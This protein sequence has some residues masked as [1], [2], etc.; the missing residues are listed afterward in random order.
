MNKKSKKEDLLAYAGSYRPLSVFGC[1]LAGI[2]AVL[3]VIPFICIWFA[4]REVF[5]NISDLSKIE[6]GKWGWLAVAFAA[7]SMA[8][9]FAGLMCTHIAAFRT[10][11]NLRS[12]ALHHLM[13][14]PLG[15]F[16]SHNS[17]RIRREIDDCASQTESYLAH[18]LPDLTAAKVTPA[19]AAILLFV[20]DWR[21][22]LISL[23]PLCISL[24]FMF[25][26]MGPSLMENMQKYQ[27]AL[28]DMNAHAVEYVRGIPI[29]KTFQQS[30]F[31]FKRFHD[32]IQSYK[33]WAV[34]Y[35]VLTTKP[36]CGYTVCINA[37]FAFLIP[38]GILLI[39]GAA[40]PSAF[41][42]D[43]I[44]YVL[45]TPLCASAFNKILWSSDQT[46]RAQ[47]AMRR[48]KA[49]IEEEPLKEAQVPQKPKNNTITFEDVSF[50]YQGAGKPAVDHISFTVP[51]GKTVALVGPSGG[52]KSTTA[53][54]IPRFWDAGHGTVKI[55]GAD[56]RSIS[57]SQ[58]MERV[59]FVFQDNHLFKATLLENIKAAN[60]NASA[61]QVDAAVKAAMCQD[62]IDKMPN[63]LQTVIGTKGV[64]LSGGEQQRIALARAFIKGA[65]VI[66]LDEA[67]A[68]A[69]PE[70]EYQIQKGFETLVKGIPSGDTSMPSGRNKEIPSGD[71]SVPSGRNKVK[72]VIMIAHRLSTVK[73]ADNIIVLEDGEIKEQ[74]A[75]D[76]LLARN[77]LY[78][79]MWTE[80][81][82]TIDWK[83]GNPVE[84]TTMAVWPNQG[85]PPKDT[86]MAIRP[87]QGNPPKDTTMA[88]RP[89]QG[90]P[91]NQR[92]ET[93]V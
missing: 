80:Y 37:G 4:V 43:F 16:T 42:L 28:G 58:L 70:N 1:V 11:K 88:I 82:S 83:V 75:H 14:L 2:S 52:G 90:N 18:Q 35:T 74:G 27:S 13:S 91:P 56:V 51:E 60:P 54:L 5:S 55:G 68:F 71:T 20:F 76:E 44:F 53:S 69:D 81:Q 25:S 36:M 3:A 93:A 8:V 65:P 72:T 29:V 45:F 33:K 15:Y 84:D 89:K 31:S 79:K 49:I 39:A 92:K 38:A 73:N 32:S 59:G 46:M 48:I 62:I 22:G 64:Y 19:A 61:Q 7:A 30:V 9:Y 67:T 21:L 86:T 47:D 66:I 12:A 41:I 85:N 78:T 24:F 87:K 50:T 34:A 10:A 26:M 77:G 23:I 40:D 63:G 6:V 17:G 57:S